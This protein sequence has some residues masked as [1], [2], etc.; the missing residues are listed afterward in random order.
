MNGR[1]S[2]EV[3]ALF[4]R[5]PGAG[6]PAAGTGV[7][8]MGEAD[9]LERGAWVR[10]DAQLAGDR[11]L[12]CGFRA[13]GCPHVLAAAARTVAGLSGTTLA[14]AR[15]PAAR[16]LQQALAVPAEKLGRLLVVEDAA[17]ALLA[18]ARAVQLR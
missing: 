18:A 13:W 10:F 3:L 2:E 5:L 12:G 14:Q 11:L 15:A 8:V 7:T 1:Y 9:A 6:A 17:T 4:E 16:D